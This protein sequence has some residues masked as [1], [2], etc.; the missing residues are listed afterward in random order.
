[1]VFMLLFI[2]IN[3]VYS[4]TVWKTMKSENKVLKLSAWF[5][6]EG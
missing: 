3:S 1:M 5:T 4:Q 2:S 6:A